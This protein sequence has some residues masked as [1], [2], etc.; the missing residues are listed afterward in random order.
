MNDKYQ[1][2]RNELDRVV[3]QGLIQ[4]EIAKSAYEAFEIE[5]DKLWEFFFEH[6]ELTMQISFFG[7]IKN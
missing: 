7:S 2:L 4:Q 1:E 6:I 5:R 3:Q